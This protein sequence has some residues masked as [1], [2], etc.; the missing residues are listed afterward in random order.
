M[1]TGE[2]SKGEAEHWISETPHLVSSAL[3]H[4]RCQETI[5]LNIPHSCPA[6]LLPLQDPGSAATTACSCQERLL[7]EN[8]FKVTYFHIIKHFARCQ[9]HF[10]D[11][12]L[13]NN[14]SLVRWAESSSGNP[15]LAARVLQGVDCARRIIPHFCH[16]CFLHPTSAF[17][18]KVWDD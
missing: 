14:L 16:Y 11:V 15:I 18:P 12:L 7:K 17:I 6:R 13:P 10:L 9:L 1:I 2:S 8:K 5:A 3:K 4:N